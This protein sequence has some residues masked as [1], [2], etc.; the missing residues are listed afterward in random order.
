LTEEASGTMGA[1]RPWQMQ[2]EKGAFGFDHNSAKKRK[3]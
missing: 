2:Q 1:F 3:K